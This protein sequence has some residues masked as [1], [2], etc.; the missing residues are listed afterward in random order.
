MEG[1]RKLIVWKKAYEFGLDLYKATKKY[2]REELYGIVSQIRRAVLSINLNI[3]EGQERKTKKEFLYF[4][5]IAKGS[6]G[7]IEALLMFSNDLEYIQ[8]DDYF[9]FEEKRREI[10]KMLNGLIKSIKI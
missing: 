5:S 10:G 3:A 6:L 1:F 9:R 2:P 4:L 7:E 8:K